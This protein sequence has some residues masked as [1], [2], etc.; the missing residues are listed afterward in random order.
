MINGLRFCMI[1]G[2]LCFTLS[3]NG[4]TIKNLK[5]HYR[6][7]QVFLVWKNADVTNLQYHV[8]RSVT[9]FTS[10]S[11]LNSDSYLGFVVDSSSKNYRLS[12][13]DGV[14]IFYRWNVKG[15]PVAAG[16]GLYA[17]TC[18]DDAAFYYAV[19]VEDNSTGIEEKSIIGGENSLSLPVSETVIKPQ[20]VLQDS[21]LMPSGIWKY[22]YV[23]YCNNQETPLYPAMNS[24]GSYGFN[25]FII[26]RGTL[27]SA[28]LMV[29]YQG[30]DLAA[31]AD[32]SFESQ[33]DNCWI[34]GVDDWLPIRYSDGRFGDNVYYCCYHEHFNIYTDKNPIPSS[35]IIKTYPQKRVM[36]SIKWLRDQFGIDSTSI[37]VRGS[38]HS[39][40]AALFTAMIYPGQ[41]A[42]YYGIVEPVSLSTN[43]DSVYEQMWGLDQ[44]DLNTDVINYK[45]G[46]FISFNRLTTLK[47]MLGINSERS[48]PVVF[49]VH[50]KNDQTIQ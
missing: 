8:Y 21:V 41:I 11:Q 17:I 40:I 23:Q 49:D 25:F 10:A 38:S 50:G 33:F 1:I 45:T 47:K 43:G 18:M 5:A 29:S 24:T 13:I 42:A 30:D 28:P 31:S 16:K 44:T 6:N 19:M 9:K 3:V 34:L 22:R 12:T 27:I 37:Y 48:V 46:Q 7:G 26:K 15:S 4:F 32:V 20:P 39:G 35:G 2:F 14:N 36:E